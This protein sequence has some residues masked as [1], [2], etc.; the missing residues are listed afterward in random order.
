M[1]LRHECERFDCL[2]FPGTCYW[3]AKIA[4]HFPSCVNESYCESNTNKS[5]GFRVTL[6]SVRQITGAEYKLLRNG[7]GLATQRRRIGNHCTMKCVGLATGFGSP[8]W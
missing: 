4:S 1:K 2:C 3:V 8:V 7:L 6:F 5:P